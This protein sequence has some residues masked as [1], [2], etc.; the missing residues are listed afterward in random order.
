M[1][2]GTGRET[3]LGFDSRLSLSNFSPATGTL[4][5]AASAYKKLENI[6]LENFRRK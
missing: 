3:G 6:K 1:D 4:L 5:V 2:A